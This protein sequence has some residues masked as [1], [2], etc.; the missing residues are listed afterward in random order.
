MRK[1]TLEEELDG[2]QKLAWNID[3]HRKITLSEQGVISGLNR[4]SAWVSAH[5]DHNGERPESEVQQNVNDAF[6]KHIA[7]YEPKPLPPAPEKRG[8]GRPRKN[9]IV[10]SEQ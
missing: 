2:W 9:P 3:M 7:Q 4:M 8:V 1:P 6:W 10:T 5:S